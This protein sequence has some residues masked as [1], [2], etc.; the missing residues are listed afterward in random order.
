[1][2]LESEVAYVFVASLYANI[3]IETSL[4]FVFLFL[5]KNIYMSSHNQEEAM[6]TEECDPE[7]T[8]PTAL[9]APDEPL[10]EEMDIDAEQY[11][12]TNEEEV[13]PDEEVFEVTLDEDDAPLYASASLYEDFSVNPFR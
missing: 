7:P 3:F 1:M 10:A 13:H 6:P 4:L 8:M 9:E 12:D 11:V 5:E 2:T